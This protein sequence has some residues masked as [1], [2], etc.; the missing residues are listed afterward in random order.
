MPQYFI[1]ILSELV[2]PLAHAWSNILD[3]YF[4]NKIFQRLSTLILFT[5]F[6][7]ILFLPIVLFTGMPQILSG[8][9]LIIVLVIALIEVAYQY[10]YYWSFRSSDTSIVASL[11]SLGKVSVPLLAFLIL[12]EKL[13]GVQYLGF[14]VIIISSALLTFDFKKFHLNRALYSMVSVSI[15]LAFQAVLYKYIFNQGTTWPSVI[16]WATFFEFL[17]AIITIVSFSKNRNDFKS[18]AYKARELGPIFVFNQFLTWIGNSGDSYALSLI[19]VSVA[20]SISSLQ[21]FFVLFYT[22]L[23]G[24]KLPHLFKEHL[25]SVG[26]K[27]KMI[28]FFMIIIGTVLVI[29]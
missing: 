16:V 20:K 19:P 17:I 13:A 15:L 12:K 28:F 10:P 26:L 22:V 29:V 5:S 2:N 27:K 18:S 21:P 9:V 8:K 25:G 7:N 1:G 24:K 4:S 3:S 6:I 23:F 11:F 14:G